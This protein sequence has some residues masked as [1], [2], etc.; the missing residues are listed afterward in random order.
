MKKIILI[1]AASILFGGCIFTPDDSM[2]CHVVY[3]PPIMNDHTKNCPVVIKILP[4][5]IWTQGDSL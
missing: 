5:F 2:R 3:V 4:A 1:V